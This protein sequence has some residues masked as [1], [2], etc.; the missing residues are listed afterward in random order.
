MSEFMV[1]VVEVCG[2]KVHGANIIFV[3]GG[4]DSKGHRCQ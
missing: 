2:E 3:C 1:K 4:E